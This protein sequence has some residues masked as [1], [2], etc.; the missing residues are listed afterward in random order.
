MKKQI[1]IC[2]LLTIAIF[3]SLSLVSC[4]A[5]H[6]QVDKEEKKVIENKVDTT[7]TV[8]KDTTHTKVVDNSKTDNWVIEPKDTT[9]PI[10]I[11]GHTYK[12]A[13]IKHEH[14][15]NNIVVDKSE[16]IATIEQKGVTDNTTTTLEIK[17]KEVDRKA[18]YWWLFW[19]LLLIPLYFLWKKYG[20]LIK[21]V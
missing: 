21:F 17:K 14:K 6:V 19:L 20:G 12:N 15:Q 1:V 18:S 5:R 11:D 3:A 9:K 2:I 10:V 16:N 13:I 8:I 7:R 4:G